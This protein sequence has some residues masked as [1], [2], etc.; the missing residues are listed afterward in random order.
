M[1]V[2]DERFDIEEIVHLYESRG[3]PLVRNKP[4]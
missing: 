1:Q 4:N 3:F 2:G